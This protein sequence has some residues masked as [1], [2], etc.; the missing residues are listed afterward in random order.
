MK[1]SWD[2]GNPYDYFMGRW[3][4]RVAG[5]FIDWLAPRAGLRW[6]DVGCA[7]GSLSETIIKG[8]RPAVLTALDTSDNF[9]AAAQHKLGNR[10]MCMVGDALALPLEDASVDVAV[11]GLV[12]NVVP[13]PEM[14]LAEMKRVTAHG[15]SVAAYVWDYGG[16]MDFLRMFWDAVVTL[17][18]EA[19][20]L[21]EA[22]RFPNTNPEALRS[23][24]ESVG[25]KKIVTVPIEIVTHFCDFD[26][27]W[28][29]FL[30]G[31]GPAPSYLQALPEA[32]R[33]TLREL[34]H[35]RLPLQPDGSISL[36]A[37][38]WA[39]RGKV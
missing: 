8:R 21:H 25:L 7:T 20:K 12:L 30:G 26:D 13:E 33:H 23:Q 9:V 27:F 16:R 24:F 38:A 31:Q 4:R 34:L 29:P 19:S 1:D 37:R 6:L 32:D 5:L 3:S 15:G 17:D 22:I 35:K 11:S 14:A 39:T 18:P 2:S 10:A 28:K 36:L